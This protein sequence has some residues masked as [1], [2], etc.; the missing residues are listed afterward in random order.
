MHLPLDSSTEKCEFADIERTK[1]AS[2]EEWWATIEL[3][4]QIASR[5]AEGHVH[6][7]TCTSFRD[8]VEGAS[9]SGL[10]ERDVLD[11]DREPDQSGAGAVLR[12]ATCKFSVTAVEL[13]TVRDDPSAKKRR[14]VNG[15]QHVSTLRRDHAQRLD[16][17]QSRSAH[18][19]SQT[20]FRYFRGTFVG[21]SCKWVLHFFPCFTYFMLLI[22]GRSY[23]AEGSNIGLPSIQSVFL[24][25]KSLLF[26]LVLNFRKI[27]SYKC[28]RTKCSHFIN[29]LYDT[30]TLRKINQDKNVFFK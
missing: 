28:W 21:G 16:V 1:I 29:T 3:P 2:C 11:A 12:H 25:Q 9:A 18:G 5:V 17:F 7:A 26:G 24:V 14:C 13:G 23:R 30:E 20:H 4:Q 27:V 10:G 6:G 22:Q 8:G 15:A 19:Q